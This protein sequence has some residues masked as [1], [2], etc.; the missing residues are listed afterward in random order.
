MIRAMVSDAKS[1][2]YYVSVCF[3]LFDTFLIFPTQ[4][5]AAA[6]IYYM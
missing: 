2:S 5:R 3:Q 6:E 4:H 1:G